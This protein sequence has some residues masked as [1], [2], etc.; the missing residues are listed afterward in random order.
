MGNQ[1][2]NE[3]S[4]D[5]FITE[6]NIREI[7]NVQDSEIKIKLE[8]ICGLFRSNKEYYSNYKKT[9][10]NIS[11]GSN[12]VKHDNNEDDLTSFQPEEEVSYDELKKTKKFCNLITFMIKLSFHKEFHDNYLM[13]IEMMGFLCK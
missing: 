3:Y 8:S 4:L 2:S 12:D 1:Q 9:E 5:K 6:L 10:E 11:G 13:I 7:H